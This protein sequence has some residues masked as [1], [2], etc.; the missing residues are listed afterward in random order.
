M[1][2]PIPCRAGRKR[3]NVAFQRCRRTRW[4]HNFSFFLMMQF[5]C[6]FF[7]PTFK[8]SNS[9]LAHSHMKKML[10]STLQR[11]SSF[12]PMRCC[13]GATFVQQFSPKA[14]FTKWKIPAWVEIQ[15]LTFPLNRDFPLT[16]AYICRIQHA[17]T[18]PKHPEGH[19]KSTRSSW[20]SDVGLVIVGIVGVNVQAACTTGES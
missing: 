20:T 1:R 4:M 6:T 10:H 13:W 7:L 5:L 11:N 14:P 9:N 17:Q 19:C 18:F 15:L 8:S 2:G 3:L 12:P 16:F